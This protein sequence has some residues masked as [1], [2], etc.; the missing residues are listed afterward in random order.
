MLVT[1]N[2]ITALVRF[3]GLKPGEF[4]AVAWS[5]VYFFSLLSAYYMLRSVR[6]AMA[7]MGGTQN[8][9]WLFTG[10]FVAMLLVTPVFGFVASRY[11]RKQFLPWVYYFFIFNIL[12][13]FSLFTYVL[14]NDLE[15]VWIARSSSH[16]IPA[17]T[18]R[19]VWKSSPAR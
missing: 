15:S 6:D 13:F 3:L 19:K 18:R 10:T 16:Q 1:A 5:F 2:R 9:P 7:I 8:I 14:R 12:I 17:S 4:F 11:P